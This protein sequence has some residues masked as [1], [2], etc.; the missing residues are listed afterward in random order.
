MTLHQH[1]AYLILLSFLRLRKRR[2]TTEAFLCM[3]LVL[4]RK[5]RHRMVGKKWTANLPITFVGCKVANV[6]HKRIAS[7]STLF[8]KWIHPSINGD[9]CPG[10]KFQKHVRIHVLKF[11]SFWMSYPIP[12]LLT[13]AIVLFLSGSTNALCAGSSCSTCTATSGCG[14]CADSEQC[15][16][17]CCWCST[18]S[19]GNG[20]HLVGSSTGPKSSFSICKLHSWYVEVIELRLIWLIDLF[21]CII[22]LYYIISTQLTVW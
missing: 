14:W 19:C 3:E 8:H 9:V 12:A 6:R 7:W 17:G 13:L 20:L 2:S 1:N 21:Y 11:S 22:L 15:L 4:N 5:L 18:F 16:D 10:H